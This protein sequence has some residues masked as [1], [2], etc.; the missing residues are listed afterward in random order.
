ML[1]KQ[2]LGVV[3]PRHLLAQFGQPLQVSLLLRRALLLILLGGVNGCADGGHHRQA[4]GDH[5]QQV[6]RARGEQEGDYGDEWDEQAEEALGVAGV[7]LRWGGEV[8]FRDGKL[9]L[10]AGWTVNVFKRHA[11]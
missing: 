5:E 11:F 7:D 1:I 9:G 2:P 10:D 4:D 3:G 6:A 8:N